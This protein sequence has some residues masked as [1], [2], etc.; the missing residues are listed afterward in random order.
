R[1]SPA[2]PDPCGWSLRRWRNAWPGH[3]RPPRPARQAGPGWRVDAAGCCVWGGACFDSKDNRRESKHSRA[4]RSKHG[5]H[6]KK[7]ADESSSCVSPV[8]LRTLPAFDIALLA[9]PHRQG[10]GGHV[11][12][13]GGPG[14]GGGTGAQGQRSHQRA[15]GAEEHILAHHRTLLVGASV[16]AGY[17]PG[18]DVGARTDL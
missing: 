3:R 16:V 9:A 4:K 10:M 17:G 8:L 18:A 11:L 2:P 15:V 12:R 1:S 7:E 6:R 14:A 5:V 13:D